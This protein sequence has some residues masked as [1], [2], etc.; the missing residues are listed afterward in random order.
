MRRLKLMQID[1]LLS[2]FTT[3]PAETR[4]NNPVGI[5][6]FSLIYLVS[7]IQR[8]HATPPTAQPTTSDHINI[9]YIWGPHVNHMGTPR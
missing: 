3:S 9:K 1:R 6:Y 5:P 2:A 4:S 7:N 8:P